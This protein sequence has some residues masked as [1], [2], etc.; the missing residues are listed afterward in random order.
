MAVEKM[1]LVQISGRL[2]DENDVILRCAQTGFFHPELPA[3][4]NDQ[5]DAF[6]PENKENP[7]KPMMAQFAELDTQLGTKTVFSPNGEIPESIRPIKIA[8]FLKKYRTALDKIIPAQQQAENEIQRAHSALQLLDKFEGLDTSLDDI[9]RCKYLC[10]RFGRLPKDNCEK[11][12]YYDDKLFVYISLSRDSEYDWGMVLCPDEAAAET[13]DIFSSLCFE[14]L[15]VPDSVHGK[16]EDAKRELQEVLH[17]SQ[18]ESDRLQQQLEQLKAENRDAFQTYYNYLYRQN[19]T[20]DFRKYVGVNGPIFHLTGFIPAD[21]ADA[22]RKVFEGLYN[23]E[24]A[25]KP[26]DSDTRYVPPTKLKNNWFCRPFESFVRMYGVP[27]YGELDP[28][29]FFAVSYTLLFGIMFGDL[30]QGLVIALLGWILAK[31]KHMDFGRILERI[32]L[33]SAIF[34]ILYGSVFGLEDVLTPMYRAMGFADKPIHVMEANTTSKLLIAAI[35]LGVVFIVISIVMNIILGFRTKKLESALFS[36]NGIAGLV[37]YLAILAGAVSMLTGGPNLFTPPY[38]AL[39]IVLPIVLMFLKEPLG[40]LL[41]HRSPKPDE[42][43]GSFIIDSFFELFDIMLSY[44]TNTMSF[45]RVGGFIIS[46]AGMMAVV[47]TLTQM[48]NG[49]GSIVAMIFGNAFVMALEGFIVGIQV[50][51]LEFYE[52]FGHYFDGQ[53]TPFEPLQLEKGKAV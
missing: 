10:V 5:R 9:F 46:H 32:G 50:L 42:S 17:R 21:R 48:M 29:P 15:Y 25:V 18:A 12:R 30:G 37:F 49:A 52:M 35:A 34:G 7:Y 47:L 3:A 51:R 8:R 13:D 33:S 28:T 19:E 41:K 4:V 45:L 14:R 22:F 40:K 23:V 44:I 53:G 20:F 11:L 43:I 36:N 6:V 2:N 1:N 31:F 27:G 39:L 16:P 24:V 38:I 26:S